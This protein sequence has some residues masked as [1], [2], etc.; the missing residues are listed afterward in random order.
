MKAIQIKYL[1]ATDYQGS[2]LKVWAEGN[3]ATIVGR[4]YALDVNDQA[5]ALAE[6]YIAETFNG[7]C[8]LYGFGCLPNGDY[9]ATLGA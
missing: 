5:R 4:D 8:K 1:S 9:V 3:K 7:N 2:R 6:R